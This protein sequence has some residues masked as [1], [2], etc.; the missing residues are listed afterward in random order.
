M[1]TIPLSALVHTTVTATRDNYQH[2]CG[3]VLDSE[4]C[5]CLVLV[6]LQ[7]LPC[8]VYLYLLEVIG[9]IIPPHDITKVF[10]RGCGNHESVPGGLHRYIQT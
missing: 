4:F 6:D 7:L 9:E 10:R 2:D 5:E 8:E 1:P 3:P